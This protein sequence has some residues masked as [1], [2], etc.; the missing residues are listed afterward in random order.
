MLKNNGKLQIR[1]KYEDDGDCCMYRHGECIALN[2]LDEDCGTYKCVFYKPVGFE[3]YRRI[4]G[5]SMVC[6]Y[7]LDENV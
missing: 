6:L 5:C 4:D 3:N 2:Q 7:P 1:L